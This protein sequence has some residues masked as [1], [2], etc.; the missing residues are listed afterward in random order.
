[1][2]LVIGGVRFRVCLH[3]TTQGSL[4]LVNNVAWDVK[5]ISCGTARFTESGRTFKCVQKVLFVML[6]KK[7][8]IQ[9]R[10]TFK[11]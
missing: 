4:H 8:L 11:F 1:M 10:E 2:Y 7:R 9:G 5:C 6:P 3:S